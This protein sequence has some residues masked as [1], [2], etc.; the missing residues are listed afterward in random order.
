MPCA[1]EKIIMVEVNGHIRSRISYDSG[2][3]CF[4]IKLLYLQE[5]LYLYYN[6]VYGHQTWQDGGLP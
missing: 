6:S 2:I 3:L 5:H 4:E 1:L